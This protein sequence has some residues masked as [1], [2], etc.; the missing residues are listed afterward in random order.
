ALPLDAVPLMRTASQPRRGI[1]QSSIER[2]VLCAD[3]Q[4]IS[5][6]DALPRAEE[7]G[8][9]AQPLTAVKSF[10]TLMPS[11]RSAA[12]ELNVAELLER[13]PEGTGHE[14]ALGA[15]RPI[16]SRGRRAHS[17]EPVGVTR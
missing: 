17:G 8:V 4:G 10:Y 6:F 15:G 14:D 13:V 2:L 3:A 16:G 5:L 12:Q 11:L 7:A 9:G 1:G